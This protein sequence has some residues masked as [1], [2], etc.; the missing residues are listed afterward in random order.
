MSNVAWRYDD[1]RKLELIFQSYGLHQYITRGNGW[2]VD[3]EF[4]NDSG[5]G[6]DIYTPVKTIQQ[7][8]TLIANK[9]AANSCY[10]DE[11][12]FLMPT[13]GIDYDDDAVGAELA[14]AYIYVNQP[15]IKIVGV[16]P[17]GSVVI[18]PG[19]AATAGV[20]NLGADADRFGLKNVWINTA[21]AQSAAIKLAAGANFP[22]IEDCL[23]NLVGAAGPLGVGID[24]DAGKVSYPIIKGCKFYL[25]TLI[26]GG[27]ILEVQDAYPFG[28]LVQD[29]DFITVLNGSGTGP[30]DVINVK[31]GTGLII[32]D[33]RI[34]GGDS[35]TAYNA[36]DGIDIDAGVLN[37]L[38][39]SCHISGC[40]NQITDGG[41]DTD[42][43]QSFSA[44]DEGEEFANAEVYL[45][46]S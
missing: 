6:R 9:R 13:N 18:N 16:G 15:N 12:I 2:I 20:I 26:L 30:A 25:G 42:I 7:A 41:T 4:G 3:A 28:G 1:Q 17:P 37:T 43:I 29:C 32:R 39:D 46:V 5:G 33:T 34:F 24:M 23:F 45:G 19:V 27:L 11:Y 38:I 22:V 8:L 44:D 21:T 36:V 10:Y 35:G 31:D 40:D 14:N